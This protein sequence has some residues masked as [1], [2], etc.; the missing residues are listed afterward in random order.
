[1]L[2]PFAAH[3]TTEIQTESPDSNRQKSPPPSPP[4][5]GQKKIFRDVMAAGA[6]AG[7]GVGEAEGGRSGG[8]EEEPESLMSDD[9][10]DLVLSSS[11]PDTREKGFL[12]PTPSH[13]TGHGT[14]A[15]WH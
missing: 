8:R 9:L 6:A 5:P 1:M 15:H 2:W 4:H 12:N 10:V 13:D 14:G 11:R 3:R 7:G